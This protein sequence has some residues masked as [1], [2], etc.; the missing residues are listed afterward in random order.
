MGLKSDG[1]LW[2]WGYNAYG[3]LGQGEQIYRSS[4]IQIG[5]K[6]YKFANIC[7]HGSQALTDDGTWY[8]WGIN[9]YGQLGQG[10]ITP[11]SSPTAVPGTWR[12]IAKTSDSHHYHSH[13]I[14]TD[15]GLFSFGYNPYG[16]L[17]LND[18]I[19]R[20]SPIQIPGN[21]AYV[22]RGG[23]TYTTHGF[24]TDGTLWGWGYNGNADLGVGDTLHR[25]SPTQVGT[26]A[27]WDYNR[28]IG[29]GQHCAF[30][31]K[32]DGTLWGWGYNYYG[33]LGLG[34]TISHSNP[35][36][37]P[38]LWAKMTNPAKRGNGAYYGQYGFKYD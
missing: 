11:R 18:Q 15:G 26:D 37:I 4:P 16:N 32:T 1:T 20:S 35:I 8:R 25:S 30:A 38:G 31:F 13:G 2:A 28:G 3:A 29:Q 27:D 36:Q 33:Q 23:Y 22:E 24:K 14:R 34:D 6:T 10:D 12:H 7:Q 5:N 19:H 9:D 17:G 21:W